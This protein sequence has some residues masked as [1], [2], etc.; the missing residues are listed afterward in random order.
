MISKT[1]INERMKKKTNPALAEAI[2]IA[3]K[4][5]AEIAAAIAVPTRQ[6]AKV[7]VGRLNEVKGDVAIVA[8]KV[9]SSGEIN[10]KLKVYA[11]G[12][13][14]KAEEKLKKAGCDCKKIIDALKKGEKLKGEIIR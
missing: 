2:F 4:I 14:E 8:G 6:Q 3:K 9:L 1:K 5:N 11:L 10:K 12:F 7:N 13:S